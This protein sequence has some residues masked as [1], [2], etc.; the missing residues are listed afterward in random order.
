MN[1]KCGN[2]KALGGGGG[3]RSGLTNCEPLTPTYDQV[4][5]LGLFRQTCIFLGVFCTPFH[6]FLKH[7][8][9]L[10]ANKWL[11]DAGKPSLVQQIHVP[12]LISPF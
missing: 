9:E 11:L 5:V 3:G 12:S 7:I 6:G 1:N 10:E 2:Y 4:L 8:L